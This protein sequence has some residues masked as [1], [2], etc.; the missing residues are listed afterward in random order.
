MDGDEAPQ[1]QYFIDIEKVVNLDTGEELVGME[2]VAEEI[3]PEV[4]PNMIGR[5]QSKGDY[6]T[7]DEKTRLQVAHCRDLG[8]DVY[9]RVGGG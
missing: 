6:E 5:A 4:L 2:A 3:P 7:V 8:Y 9:F 1:G